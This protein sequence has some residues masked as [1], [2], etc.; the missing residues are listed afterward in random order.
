M[1]EALLLGGKN[2]FLEGGSLHTRE[3]GYITLPK[4][5]KHPVRSGTILASH[6]DLLF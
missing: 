4:S 5:A 2:G 3:Y 6:S 1:L